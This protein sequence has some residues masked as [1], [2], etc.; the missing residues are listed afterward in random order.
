MGINSFA[1]QRG[2]VMV[3]IFIVA[4]LFM[5]GDRGYRSSVINGTLDPHDEI[6][7]ALAIE[8]QTLKK[9]F[10]TISQWPARTMLALKRPVFPLPP[11]FETAEE[12]L[13]NIGKIDFIVFDPFD[14]ANKHLRDQLANLTGKIETLVQQPDGV[15]VKVRH[16][17]EQ[18]EPSPIL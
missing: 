18:T 6:V 15:I 8:T 4:T 13:K 1:G 11:R 5:V 14:P 10:Y 3:V 17:K 12:L 2:L 9:N 16:D 7:K